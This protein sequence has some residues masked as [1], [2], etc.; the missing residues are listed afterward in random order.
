MRIEPSTHVREHSVII[1]VARKDTCG[2]PISPTNI[3]ISPGR[4]PYAR[5]DEAMTDYSDSEKQS[6]RNAAYGAVFLVSNAEPGMLDM[7]KESF[8]ASKSFAKASGDMQGVFRGM[9]MP[10]M[11]KGNPADIEAGV[12]SELSNSVK[13]LEQKAPADA[14]AYRHIVIDAC[15]NAAQAAKGVSAPETSMLGKVSAALGS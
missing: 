5:Q 4:T 6:L 9:S 3:G 11:P 2:V 13:A 15:T 12:L 1:S 14:D 7:V 10:S 8:A